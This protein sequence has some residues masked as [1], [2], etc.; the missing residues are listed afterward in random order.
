[1]PLGPYRE[2]L[3]GPVLDPA[4]EVAKAKEEFARLEE[5]IADCMKEAGFEYT[6]RVS[7]VT[8]ESFERDL[9][10]RGG[11]LL[12]PPL[13][14]ERETVAAW[15]YGLDPP[16]RYEEALLDEMDPRAQETAAENAEYFNSLS[17]SAQDAYNTAY[18]GYPREIEGQV[19]ETGGCLAAAEEAAPTRPTRPDW[20][21]D[22]Y[23][24]LARLV[25]EVGWVDVPADAEAVALHKEWAAC[26]AD[27]GQVIDEPKPDPRLQAILEKTTGP[28][29]Y[30]GYAVYASPSRAIMQARYVDAE[31]QVT[32]DGSR[33]PFLRALPG[34]VAI[35]LA[36]FDCR[37]RTNYMDR[38]MAVEVRVEQA[39]L[40]KHKAEL[41]EM[42]EAAQ[43][44]AWD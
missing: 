37:E 10:E 12:V 21:E 9:S 39:F 41:D 16:D 5:L 23:L 31:G 36:D 40:D 32:G 1:M 38:L 28:R 3:D 35:A 29:P 43:R 20:W 27:A 8:E 18:V 25:K 11:W 30:D 6:P 13:D 15:G 17:Q 42:L 34:Q 22:Q 14:P 19:Q 26:M 33:Q 44:P 24:E 7:G 2:A 4:E